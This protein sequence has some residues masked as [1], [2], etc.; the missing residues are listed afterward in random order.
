MSLE[1]GYQY[2]ANFA[3]DNDSREYTRNVVYLGAN[4]SF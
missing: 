2:S 1:A 4:S 3:P